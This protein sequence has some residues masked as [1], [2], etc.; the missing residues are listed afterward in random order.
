MERIIMKSVKKFNS[1]GELKSRE[2]KAT[3]QPASL[4][5]HHA[6]EKFI[7][8]VKTDQTINHKSE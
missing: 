6:L 4:K 8:S 7:K 5:R 2:G 3:D 1:F